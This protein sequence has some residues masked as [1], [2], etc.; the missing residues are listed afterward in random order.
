MEKQSLIP[1]VNNVV[2]DHAAMSAAEPEP[3]PF[4]AAGE[5]DYFD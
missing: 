4:V 5:S 2:Y 3:N 1:D